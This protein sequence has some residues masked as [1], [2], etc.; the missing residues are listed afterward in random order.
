[1]SSLSLQL[2]PIEVLHQILLYL[3]YRSCLFLGW[4][5]SAGWRILQDDYFWKLK[6]LRDYPNE[7]IL[8]NRDNRDKYIYLMSEKD[9]DI[10]SQ[11]YQVPSISFERA[12]AKGDLWLI[13]Y[14]LRRH[15]YDPE[16]PKMS[17]HPPNY[18]EILIAAIKNKHN[19]VVEY[20][21]K[22]LHYKL[23]W[24]WQQC[25]L[26]SEQHNLDIFGLFFS[27]CPQEIKKT[28]LVESLGQNQDIWGYQLVLPVPTWTESICGLV[29]SKYLVGG[30]SL[31]VG[32]MLIKKSSQ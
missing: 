10:G 25:L 14:F 18:T 17:I 19:H 2:L 29:K 11:V 5:F 8:D 30:L 4:S 15:A 28:Y 27:R 12:G 20:F 9:V 16:E 24:N 22:N 13:K 7:D 21:L 32:A 3:P 26:V 6:F 1:M 23:Q 31:I